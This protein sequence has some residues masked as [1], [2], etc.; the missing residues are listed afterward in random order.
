MSRVIPC[1]A[2]PTSGW[3][4][5]WHW[6]RLAA[7]SLALALMSL[8]MQVS[9]AAVALRGAWRPVL[10]HESP[11]SV[12]RTDPGM[13]EFNPRRLHSF[14]CGKHACWILLWPDGGRWPAPPFVVEV[15]APG[16]QTVSFFPPNAAPQ[17][18]RL[19]S[20][21]NAWPGMDRVVF[22]VDSARADEPLELQI[23]PRGV[24]A[25][26]VSF[27]VH[28]IA[29]YVR[30][31]MRRTA[32]ASACFAIM[33]TVMLMAV[34]FCVWQGDLTYGY[35]AIFVLAYAVI[36]AIQSGYVAEPLGLGFVV[37]APRVWGRMATALS[38]AFAILFVSRFAEL[39][40]YAPRWRK[41]LLAYAGAVIALTA[42]TLLPVHGMQAFVRGAINPLLI[43]GTLAVL[44]ASMLA[45]VR[46]S[47]YAKFFLV[48]W[49]PLLLVNA[50][51][52]AQLYGW[53]AGWALGD[54]A[55]IGA[56]AFEAVVLAFGL[57][58]RSAVMRHEH[59]QARR[60]AETDPLT[61][62]SNRRAWNRRLAM[63]QQQTRLAGQ[64]LSVLFLDLDHFK[65]INDRLGHDAGDG[66]L[67]LIAD[68]VRRELR[69]PDEVG[70]YGG[71]EFVVALP[72]A[73]AG[74]AMQVAER[75]RQRLE[76]LAAQDS[77]GATP[78][79][80]IGVA[81]ACGGMD[82]DSLI[83]RADRAMYVAKKAG[84]N[85]VVCDSAAPGDGVTQARQPSLGSESA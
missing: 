11:A 6:R 84:R 33:L 28:T 23:D 54:A 69:D 65:A 32:F 62:L 59:N 26:P 52:S 42:S 21:A 57:A 48:G 24:I 67:Q 77:S 68:V 75:I 81:T 2:V 79:V 37:A 58:E 15:D 38:V 64:P 55:A 45:A 73:D 10:P 27:A 46:G 76:L 53:G 83:H 47:R 9:A 13:R 85:R 70:R 5:D 78:T 44:V 35:Y 16:L 30:S 74:T 49:V 7:W 72:G 50:I 1:G 4:G 12:Q 39:H 17:T 61:G 22:R 66:A 29:G 40:H 14:A 25:S 3:F 63:L 51:G 18:A 20:L 60:L 34:F 36:L 31:D 41:Y 80:S 82:T 56:G 8:A 43:V 19:M 71:E